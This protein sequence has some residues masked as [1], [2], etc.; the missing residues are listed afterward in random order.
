MNYLLM[1]VLGYLIGCLQFAYIFGRIFKGVDIRELG[2]GNSGASN[3]VQS[4]GWKYGVAVGAL[5]ILKAV[6][7]ILIARALFPHEVSLNGPLVDYWTGAA[8]VLGHNY[9]LFMDFKGGK[10]TASTVGFL[11]ALD[12]RIGIAAILTVLIVTIATDYIVIG[13]MA[14]LALILIYTFYMDFGVF[15]MVIAVGMAIQS[16]LKH[17]PNLKRI[18]RGEENGLRG[19]MK[20]K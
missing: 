6:T 5:D 1:A 19:T 13:T 20:K 15:C 17:L 4:M 16:V 3:A 8:V 12:Y 2:H 10:G 14:L 9:P 11:L 18:S 7:A